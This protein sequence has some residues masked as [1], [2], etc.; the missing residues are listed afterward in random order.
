MQT[1]AITAERR[2]VV[3]DRVEL[4]RVYMAWITPPFFK[5]GDADA[6]IASSVLGQGA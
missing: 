3:E 6:D 2:I 1:P 4:P 5:D